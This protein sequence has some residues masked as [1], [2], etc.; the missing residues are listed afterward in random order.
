MGMGGYPL[1]W[2][3]EEAA[4]GKSLP[5]N[6]VALATMFF[7]LTVYWVCLLSA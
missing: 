2:T 1:H 5:S 6:E 7:K 3:M 4:C